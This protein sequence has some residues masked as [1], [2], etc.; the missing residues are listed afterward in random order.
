MQAT[1]SN[2]NLQTDFLTAQEGS[3]IGDTEKYGC[4]FTIWVKIEPI[5]GS[6][7]HAQPSGFP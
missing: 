6:P 4:G 3:V 1:G 7:G 5:C 2:L